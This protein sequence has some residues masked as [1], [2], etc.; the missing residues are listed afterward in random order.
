MPIYEYK[1]KNCGKK[2]EEFQPLNAGNE[3]VICPNCNTPQ[4]ERLFSAF[5]S[6]GASIGTTVSSGSCGSSGSPFS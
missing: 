4:P 3:N 6:S 2:F 1:C 5:S